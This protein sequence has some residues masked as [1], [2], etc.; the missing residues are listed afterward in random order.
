MASIQD[1]CIL[2]YGFIQRVPIHIYL[3]GITEERRI[4][5]PLALG[6]PLWFGILFWEF[7][8]GHGEGVSSSVLTAEIPGHEDRQGG[9]HGAS[10]SQSRVAG[11][12]S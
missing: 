4:I 1:F 10:G 8:A 7:V 9:G 12:K 6:K 11:N 3:N 5:P 2:W